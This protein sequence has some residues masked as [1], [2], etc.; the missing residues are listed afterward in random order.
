[1]AAASGS[2]LEATLHDIVQA[3][4]RH[5]DAT[6]GAMG[7]LTADG[8]ALDR[9][10]IDGMDDADRQRI[11]RLPDGQGILG[12]LVAEPTTLRLDDLTAHPASSGFPDGHPPMRSFLGVPV[13]VGD[14]VFGNLYLTEKRNGGPFTVADVEVAQALAAVAGLAIT[15]ARLAEAAETRRR[16]DEAAVEMATALLAG[17][18]PEHVLRSVSARV[19]TLTGA[20]LTGVLAPSIDDDESLTIVAAVGAGAEEVEGVRIPLAGTDVG[21]TY[22][23]GVARVVEDIST[24]PVVGRRAATVI[25][26][27]ARF[28]PALIAPLG[29]PPDLGLLVTLRAAGRQPFAEEE[30]RSLTAFAAQ[31]SVALELARAQQRE[32][33]LQVQSDR[34][35]IARDLHD[36]V[37]QRIFATALSLDRLGRS[38]EQVH[39]D[40]AARLSRTVDDLHG[41]IARIRTSIF[42]L[43]EAEDTSAAAVRGRLAD[44]VRSVTEG[45][46]LRVDL[47]FHCERDRLPPDLVLDLIAVVRELVTNVARHAR[48]D[49]VAVSVSISTT[50]VVVVSDDGCGLPEV[51]VRSGLANL[52][53]RAERRDG[54]LTCASDDTGTE[55]RWVAPLPT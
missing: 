15:N 29:S 20:D 54:A 17:A 19:S 13:R 42:E 35:R 24:M 5:V 36:H 10:V 45:H 33:A 18:E 53:A 28:G 32:R 41:T 23:A 55:I 46:D 48:A 40:A 26:L 27:T 47:H 14:S 30:L 51:A 12:L 44:V 39:A 16:W 22:R 4:V 52:A 6:Y 7:V 21:A 38:L 9:F 43:H 2:Q 49:R 8:R 31:A 3:A 11:G 37:V 25:E 1:M 34:D 50:V